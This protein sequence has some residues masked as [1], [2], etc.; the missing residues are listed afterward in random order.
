MNSQ[1]LMQNALGLH[2]SASSPLHLFYNFQFSIL[3]GLVSVQMSES[4]TIVPSLV[5]FSFCL[6]LCFS[7]FRCVSLC[8]IFLYFHYFKT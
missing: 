8:F 7:Q 5:L 1:R 3:R 6:F 4:L 2:V